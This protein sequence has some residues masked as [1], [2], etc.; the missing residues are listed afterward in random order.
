MA[1]WTRIPFIAPRLSNIL[2]PADYSDLK[3]SR[4]DPCQL[5]REIG[6]FETLLSID[7]AREVLGFEPAHCWRDEVSVG[8]DDWT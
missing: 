5:W 1:Q 3:P 4:T 8:Q 2:G 6:E 7:Q